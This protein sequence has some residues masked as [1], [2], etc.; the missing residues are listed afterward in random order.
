[1]ILSED[2]TNAM[3]KLLLNDVDIQDYCQTV[4]S[5]PL[6]GEDNLV[7]IGS[8]IIEEKPSFT[9]VKLAEKNNFNAATESGI[10][11]EWSI[12]VTFFG[13]FGKAQENSNEFTL[14]TGAKITKNGV[15]T[16]TPSD[17]MR[18]LARKAGML[19]VKKMECTIPGILVSSFEIETED[20]YD[21]SSGEVKSFVKIEL[22]KKS[23]LYN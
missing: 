10:E 23:G 2:I 21:T 3:A 14:P 9:V 22:Y 18:V 8:L 12:E 19:A 5:K 15:P 20:Y 13:N 17:T 1:M 11:S 16:Y 6:L 7:F 4:F